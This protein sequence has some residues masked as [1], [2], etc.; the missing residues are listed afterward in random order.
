MTNVDPFRRYIEAAM[1]LLA[2]PDARPDRDALRVVCGGELRELQ[3]T[4]AVLAMTLE[5]TGGLI[6]LEMPEHAVWLGPR[7][8]VVFRHAAP[9]SPRTFDVEPDCAFWTGD[10][11]APLL[12]VS[13]AGNRHFRLSREGL[14]EGEGRPD[15]DLQE[16]FERG[17]RRLRAAAGAPPADDFL[18]REEFTGGGEL[19][20]D[21]MLELLSASDPGARA[22]MMRH[23]VALRSMLTGRLHD[24]EVEGLLIGADFKTTLEVAEQYKALTA[25]DGAARIMIGFDADD[26]CGPPAS[27]GLWHSRDGVATFYD[28]C[29]PWMPPAGG[30]A[31]LVGQNAR[32]LRCFR[33]QR[34][35]F[36]G[37]PGGP[38]K[39][40]WPGIHRAKAR[41]ARLVTTPAVANAVGDVHLRFAAQGRE[42]V[43]VTL[44]TGPLSDGDEG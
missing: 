8:V 41:M 30:R 21:F 7:R 28:R 3:Q 18:S 13:R 24:R 9:G 34:G 2:D 11:H 12:M 1:T 37:T 22:S 20:P 43:F 36:V 44:P 39:D 42:P 14:V 40:P 35:E 31:L 16:G 15:G 25:A 5:T 32:E 29:A 23:T 4:E 10:D 38:A 27:F 33:Y 17:T 6:Y 26:P 19:D